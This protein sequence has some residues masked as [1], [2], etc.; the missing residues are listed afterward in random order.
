MILPAL[1][2]GML[3]STSL[4]FANVDSDGDGVPDLEDIY[5]W[6]DTKSA[7]PIHRLPSIVEAEDY[8]LGGQGIA[9]F[10]LHCPNEEI[11]YDLWTTDDIGFGPGVLYRGEIRP[12]F[13]LTP[14]T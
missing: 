10:D 3:L 5:P 13:S 6:D 11:V 12:G 8:D 9:Y 4:T 7:L 1:M 2:L 14:T